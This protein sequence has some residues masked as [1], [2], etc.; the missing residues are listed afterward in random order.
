M[1]YRNGGRE[2]RI[3]PQTERGEQVLLA[4]LNTA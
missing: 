3:E 2:V 1:G 4:L